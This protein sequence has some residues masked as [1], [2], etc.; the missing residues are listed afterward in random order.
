MTHQLLYV[1]D[2]TLKHEVICH[3]CLSDILDKYCK[4]WIFQIECGDGGY[5]HYQGKIS[6]KNRQRL[7][8]FKNK[9][10]EEDEALKVIHLS[11]SMTV[12]KRVFSYVMKED[13]R[14]EGPFTDKKYKLDKLKYIPKQYDGKLNTLYPFQISLINKCQIFNDRKIILIYDKKGNIGKSTI[15]HLLRLHFNGIVL[16]I[17]NDAE[18]L[19]QSCCNILMSRD[20]RK[21]IPICIDLPRAMS[22]DK[23]FQ[24]YSAIE[25]IKSGYVYDVRNHFKDWNYDSPCI[26][27]FTNHIPN[28]DLLSIDRW[29][30]YVIDDDKQL[31]A[32]DF[33]EL[34]Y[35]PFI[36]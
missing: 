22:K 14:I 23:L 35:I 16:P 4:K 24:M 27:V 26:I 5:V 12:N 2:F 11:P 18:K 15:S 33:D 9:L 8:S 13:T 1:Y 31:I 6:L 30:P 25:Q 36:E 10:M 3:E 21:S 34:L 19:I 7:Q 17:V 29:D 32:T 28:K 20:V